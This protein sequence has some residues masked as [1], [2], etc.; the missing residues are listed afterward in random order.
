MLSVWFDLEFLIIYFS[1]YFAQLQSEAKVFCMHILQLIEIFQICFQT[2]YFL[3]IQKHPFFQL[4]CAF[5]PLIFA[6]FIFFFI[7]TQRSNVGHETNSEA[8]YN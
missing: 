4:I 7:H 2:K 3:Y 8:T 6:H 5:S 1:I